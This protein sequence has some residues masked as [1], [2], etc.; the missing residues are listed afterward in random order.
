MKSILMTFCLVAFIGLSS[1][2]AQR[3]SFYIGANAGMNTSKYKFTEDLRELYPTSNPV[4]GLNGGVDAG[5][6][7]DNWV[8]STGIHYMQ[9]GSEYQT[10]NFEDNGSTGFFTGKEKL[11]FLTI[12]VLLGYQQELI[13]KVSWSINLGPS[14]NF[15]LAGN[16]DET[17]E[18]F[19]SDEVDFQN[20]KVSYGE[21]VND[22][23]RK[24]QIGFQINPA[25]HIDVNSWSK[26]KLGVAWDFGTGDMYSK[27]YKSANEFF[28][29][30][31][32]NQIHKNTTFTVG[33]QYHFPFEDKY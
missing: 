22:D 25:L 3:S 16:I 32:G 28:D 11:H 31:K 30:N 2:T 14:F 1:M 15:G 18:F 5:L 6:K 27:R 21:G 12:P 7:L 26:I 20:F 24:M 8:I 9:K 13:D 23:Y 4:L 29:L 33:Y 17:T 19:G 10:N